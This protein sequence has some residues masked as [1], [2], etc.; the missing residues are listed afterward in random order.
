MLAIL[1]RFWYVIPLLGLLIT[2]LVMRNDLTNTHAKLDAAQVRVTDL[3]KANKTLSDFQAG[4]AAMRVDNDAIATAI[5]GKI[6]I[7]NTRE[8]HT[9]EVIEKAVR[10]DPATRSWADSPVPVSV[11]AAL[12]PNPK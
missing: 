10:N 1:K 7:N 8:V 4:L 12:R 3:T 5:A 2:V 6:Q 9:R 11:R